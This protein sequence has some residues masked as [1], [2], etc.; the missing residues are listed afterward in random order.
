MIMAILDDKI[1]STFFFLVISSHYLHSISFHCCFLL[2][3][4]N[5]Y[6]YTMFQPKYENIDIHNVDKEEE[7]NSRKTKRNIRKFFLIFS[8][9]INWNLNEI[10]SLSY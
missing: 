8:Y 10:G 4:I 5:I 6:I 9:G 2:L 7:D 3:D 1:F